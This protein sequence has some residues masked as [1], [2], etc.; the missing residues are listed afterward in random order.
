[1]HGSSTMDGGKKR[2]KEFRDDRNK[3]EDPYY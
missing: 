3:C 2:E 1:M